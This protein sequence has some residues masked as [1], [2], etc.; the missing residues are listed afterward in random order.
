[1]CLAALNAASNRTAA[2]KKPFEIGGQRKVAWRF[3]WIGS[4]SLLLVAAFAAPA[5]SRM[6][7]QILFYA[8][9]ARSGAAWYLRSGQWR[10]DAG[11]YMT[12]VE[13][14]FCPNSGAGA[15]IDREPDE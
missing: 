8:K 1:M 15:R 4:I 10:A 6:F 9:Y 5:S 2:M 13:H 7:S 3:L 14:L 12:H 11:D